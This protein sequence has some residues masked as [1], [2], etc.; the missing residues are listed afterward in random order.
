MPIKG[1]VNLPGDKSISHRALMLASLTDN[2][3]IIHNLSTGDDVETTRNC[4]SECGIAS[5]REGATIHIKGGTF[6]TP[7]KVLD[8]G[9]SGTSV[10]LLAGLLAG[11]GIS[12]EFIGDSSLSKRPM[13][14]IIEPLSQMGVHFKSNDGCLPITISPSNLK[15]ITYSP[16]IASAQVKSAVLLA[17]L[18]AEGETVVV[19]TLKTRDHTE[20]M[21]VEMG[22]YLT[23]SENIS[24]RKL[25]T[26]LHKFELTV[27]GDPS[28][29][30]FFGAAAAMIPNSDITIKNVLANPT[31]IGFFSVLEK[32]GA[33][34]ELMNMHKECGEWVGDVHIFSQPLNGIDITKEMVPSIID[35]LPIIAVLASQ[36]D[37]P[38]TVSGAEEL[39]VK[40][41]DRINAVCFNLANMGCDVIERHD[42]FI[43]NPEKSL[44]HTSIKTFRDHRIAMAFTVAGLITSE[45]NKLD[46]ENCINISFPEFNA[47]LHKVLI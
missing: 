14:R 9:N 37:S 26:P 11:Q 21:L 8:C 46:D 31:R 3:C 24:I 15:G 18:G 38:T 39:R 2:E 32:M 41:S 29:A 44:H 6:K 23:V 25:D 30:A 13:N 35:E 43:I 33:G 40:E 4:L 45:R 17:G 1:I 12:A 5:S 27:P 22:A 36:A 10:R 16:P 19:E 20:L 42:G 34:F 47:L 7:K 28:S